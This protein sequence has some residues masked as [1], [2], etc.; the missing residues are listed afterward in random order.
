MGKAVNHQENFD[1]ID[2]FFSEQETGR[3]NYITGGTMQQS[4][5]R[6]LD[7]GVE[8]QDLRG[9]KLILALK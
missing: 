3:T 9:T 2:M 4:L 1:Y 6:Y 5:R 8:N 7:C